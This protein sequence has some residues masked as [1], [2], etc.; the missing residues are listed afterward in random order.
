M[1]WLFRYVPLVP[2]VAIWQ[3]AADSGLVH[4]HFLP[5]F[6]ETIGAPRGAGGQR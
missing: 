3:A 4:R 2:F 5:S 1:R 6:S